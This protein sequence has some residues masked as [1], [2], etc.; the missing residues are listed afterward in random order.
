MD[1]EVKNKFESLPKVLRWIG[2]IVLIASALAFVLQGW[3]GWSSLVRYFC[4]LGFTFSLASVGCF[5]ALKMKDDKGARTFLGV[6]AAFLPAHFLQLGALLYSI[7][8]D[9][10]ANVPS[11]FLLT[12]PSVSAAFGTLAVAMLVLV[13]VVFFGL[14]AMA[15]SQASE[16]TFVY[17]IANSMLLIPVRSANLV[18]LCVMAFAVVLAFAEIKFFRPISCMQTW[19]GRA[20]RLMMFVPLVLALGRNLVLYPV[21]PLLVSLVCAFIAGAMFYALPQAV[22]REVGRFFQVLSMFPLGLA[23]LF[24][25]T[26]LFFDPNGFFY[27]LIVDYASQLRTPIFV[28]PFA[29]GV[30]LLSYKAIGEGQGYRQLAAWGAILAMVSHLFTVSGVLSSFL[31]I[32]TAIVV[33]I[34][35]FIQEDRAQL[36]AGGVGLV[37]GLLHQLRYAVDL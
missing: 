9:S 29:T 19:E 1:V 31:C 8:L 2:G 23:W 20:V 12:A 18:G 24:M 11:F 3:A 25:A 27:S 5:C 34:L 10:P 15:R 7:T 32:L 17:F 14:S 26:A 35:A 4:F 21:T 28:L 6:A 16:L 33:I 37:L 13:P 30:F 36:Y 22:E